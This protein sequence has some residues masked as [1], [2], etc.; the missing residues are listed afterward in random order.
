[1]N[2]TIKIER[3]GKDLYNRDLAYLFYENKN[4]NLELVKKGYANYYFPSSKDKYYNDFVFA[5]DSCTENLC[6]KSNN[7]CAS[8][9]NLELN[10]KSDEIIIENKCSYSCDLTNFSVKDEGRKKF[11]FERFVLESNN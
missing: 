11:I 8:C 3:H 6:E 1:M 10:V 9:L 2:K 7:I 4:I 5:F